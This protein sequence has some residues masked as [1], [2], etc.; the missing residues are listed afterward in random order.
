M[1][2]HASG[3]VAPMGDQLRVG[4][5]KSGPIVT[6]HSKS[7]R[8]SAVPVERNGASVQVQVAVADA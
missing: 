1:F 6:H 4:F 7:L 2:G 8:H 3:T 5:I